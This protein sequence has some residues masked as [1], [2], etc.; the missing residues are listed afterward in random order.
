MVEATDL[1][2]QL[3]LGNIDRELEEF[4]SDASLQVYEAL[5]MYPARHMQKHMKKSRTSAAALSFMR[6]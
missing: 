2:Q 4:A 6:T 1:I 5:A 3:G